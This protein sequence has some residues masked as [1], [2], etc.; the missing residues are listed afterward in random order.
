MSDYDFYNTWLGDLTPEGLQRPLSNYQSA[1]VFR[2]GW[3]DSCGCDSEHVHIEWD[4]SVEKFKILGIVK[5]SYRIHRGANGP[6]GAEAKYYTLDDAG[7]LSKE[8]K[9]KVDIDGAYCG[10][11]EAICAILRTDKNWKN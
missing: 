7:K 8:P 6:D 10:H 2:E 1:L 3:G 9:Y 11:E 4:K 5:S